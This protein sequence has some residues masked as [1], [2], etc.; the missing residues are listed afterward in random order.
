M[1]GRQP[2]APSL[3]EAARMRANAETGAVSTSKRYHW[4]LPTDDPRATNEFP[5]VPVPKDPY[6]DTANIK[7][8]YAASTA[9]TN[10]V[11]PFDGS[12][13]QYLM[14]KRDAE[15]KAE[16]DAWVMQKFDITDPAQNLMLQ[17]I[18]P[19]LYQ[20]REEVI[21]S[22]QA[23]VNAY[24]KARLR[25]AKNMSDLELEWLVETGRL[26]LPEG[27]IWNPTEWR[28]AQHAQHKTTDTQTDEEWNAER[29]R[30]G[31]FSP[32][33]WLTKGS[34]GWMPN[35]ANRSDIH[36]NPKDKY[37]PGRVPYPDD[38]YQNVWDDPVPY[39]YAGANTY[40]AAQSA[41]SALAR[42]NLVAQ[43]GSRGR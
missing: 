15:E 35:K 20:R 6:D 31:L 33:L 14:R 17:N 42:A 37:M 26:Q 30:F 19:D 27:P 40:G 23:L 7:A 32:L 10:W 29:Y 43:N 16:F 36:G 4:Q 22:Q 2:G 12:D 18:A 1:A 24:A 38:R 9:G 3:E 34:A 5:I 25:G 41:S 13:A 21:E 8:Q 39:P 11:V 28:N